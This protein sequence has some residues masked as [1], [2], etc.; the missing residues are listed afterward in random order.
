TTPEAIWN[1]YSADQIQN[2]VRGQGFD[3]TNIIT[4]ADM[5]AALALIPGLTLSG[6][7]AAYNAMPRDPQPKVTNTLDK[8]ASN[9]PVDRFLARVRTHF[10]LVPHSNDQAKNALLQA[11]NEKL[12]DF[13]LAQFQDG[14]TDINVL[15]KRVE[16]KY[17]PNAFQY[18]DLFSSYKMPQG[19]TAQEAGTELRRLYIQ[20]LGYTPA[21]VRDNEAIIA[22]A[23]SGRLLQVLPQ[24]VAAILR[25][26][27]LD[28]PNKTWEAILTKANQLMPTATAK[29]KTP[30]ASSPR[31]S[32]Y[33][34]VHG[35]RG[36][37]DAECY[38]QHGGHPNAQQ[39]KGQQQK[40]P[41]GNQIKCFSCYQYGHTARTCPASLKG[42]EGT[43]SP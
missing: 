39:P 19:Y 8:Q 13:L 31:N 41:S 25:A 29:T 9:E 26:E 34:S 4:K 10:E 43:G 21:E 1:L 37:T 23:L 2:M 20:F 35:Y 14:V 18:Y 28:D 36:H 22:K 15:L 12:R 40:G 38:A 3:M 17:T 24:S 7:I 6:A 30:A 27:L 32:K 5:V 33:C 11:S 42:N 16:D